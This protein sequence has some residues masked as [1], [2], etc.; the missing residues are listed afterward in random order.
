MVIFCRNPIE[1]CVSI[2]AFNEHHAKV[3]C[4]DTLLSVTRMS[5][6]D[7]SSPSKWALK[8]DIDKIFSG[9]FAAIWRR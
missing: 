6:R 8:G 1:T 2:G 9:K 4:V 3:G 5:G 7:L